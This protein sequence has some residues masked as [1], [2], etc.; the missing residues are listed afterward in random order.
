MEVTLRSGRVLEKRKE[1]E[2]MMTEKDK[3]AETGKET[4][5]DS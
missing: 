1:G 2:K 3:Q 5:L 4:K